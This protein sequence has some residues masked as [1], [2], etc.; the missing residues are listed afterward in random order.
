M[1]NVYVDA[2]FT[3]NFDKKKSHLRDTARLR[4]GYIIMNEG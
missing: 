4:H 2:D 3:G 1:L